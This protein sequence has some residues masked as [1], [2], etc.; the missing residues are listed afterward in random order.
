MR[1]FLHCCRFLLG[2]DEAATQVTERELA[3]LVQ[4][5]AASQTIVEI[6]VFEG[7]TSVALAKASPGTVYGIDPFFGGRLGLAWGEVIARANRRRHHLRNLEFIK[8]LSHDA[9][10]RFDRAVDMIFIDA[11]HSYKGLQQDWTD[12]TPKVR[13]GGIIA[14]HDVHLAPNSPERKG[15]MEFFEAEI[16]RARGFERVADIDSLAVLR[17]L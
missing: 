12:W 8:A 11:D 9:A 13:S 14:L 3:V 6:G 4:H 1:T 5:A 2:V 10:P 7:K 15:S 17:K 16:V